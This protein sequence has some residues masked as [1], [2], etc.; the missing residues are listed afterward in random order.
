MMARFTM[1][2]VPRSM[3]S[4]N[5]SLRTAM[6]PLT[7][8]SSSLCAV[9]SCFHMSS[10]S[11]SPLRGV[12]V[13]RRSSRVRLMRFKAVGLSNHLLGLRSH[14][15][16]PFYLRNGGRASGRSSIRASSSST[17]SGM[18]LKYLHTCWKRRSPESYVGFSIRRL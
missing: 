7:H 6:A 15:W 14:H 2:S 11:S 4:W 12:D 18:F 3:S 13:L 5:C 9:K 8:N 16:P 17:C 1:S 10:S